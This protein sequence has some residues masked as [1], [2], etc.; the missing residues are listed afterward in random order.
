MSK[1]DSES[2]VM[3]EK[4]ERYVGFWELYVK[5]QKAVMKNPIIVV[6]NGAQEYT[7]TNPAVNDLNKINT[8]LIALGKDMGIDAPAEMA[9]SATS[10]A[11]DELL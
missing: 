2:L 9:N 1:I 11:R 7:K 5:L 4:V 8:S 6:K 10:S 3:I